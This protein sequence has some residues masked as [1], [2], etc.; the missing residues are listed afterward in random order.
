[1]SALRKVEAGCLFWWNATT[2]TWHAPVVTGPLGAPVLTA[3]AAD[4]A[5]PGNFRVRDNLLLLQNV[6]VGQGWYH[7]VFLYGSPPALAFG[8]PEQNP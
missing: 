6:T 3:L 4:E 5:A 1:M 2:E 8:P 7:P